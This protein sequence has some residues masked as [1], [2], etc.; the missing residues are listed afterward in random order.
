M[1]H[2]S[3]GRLLLVVATAGTVSAC[4]ESPM[5]PARSAPAPQLHVGAPAS[6]C[7]LADLPESARVLLCFNTEI[8]PGVWHGFIIET[9]DAQ[10]PG[11]L[12]YFDRS[13]LNHGYI[14]ASPQGF[15][16]WGPADPLAPGAL[17]NIYAF[18]PEYFLG[19][20]RDVFRIMSASAG[21][22]V[23]PIVIFWADP[24]GVAADL[25]DAIADLRTT[26]VV[27]AGQANA[28]ARK[29]D[30]AA[31]LLA[32]GKQADAI[33][34]LQGFIQ[35]VDDLTNID[36]VLTA[37]QATQLTAWAQYLIDSI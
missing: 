24:S 5:E 22:E 25:K 18:Q 29:I 16:R 12:E 26:G 33:A 6:S 4:A 23:V 35:Q 9:S 34:V 1:R 19:L 27:N 36:F 30:Q 13:R 17:D 31:S 37:A 2:Q 3:L 28:L 8:L 14:L 7:P 20:W 32:K 10:P 15:T 21:P 11:T